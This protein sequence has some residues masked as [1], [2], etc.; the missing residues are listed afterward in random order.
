MQA[1]APLTVIFVLSGDRQPQQPQQLRLVV[2][3]PHCC[4]ASDMLQILQQRA[5]APVVAAVS[6]ADAGM[7]QLPADVL[8]TVS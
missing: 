8:L 4:W 7:A 2:L 3:A 6:L 5:Q 1:M